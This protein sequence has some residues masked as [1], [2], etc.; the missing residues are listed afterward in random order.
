[1][2]ELPPGLR[3]PQRGGSLILPQCGTGQRLESVLGRKS[4]IRVRCFH[5]CQ[6]KRWSIVGRERLGR[7]NGVKL[8]EKKPPVAMATGG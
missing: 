7:P 6:V 4:G 8:G 1:M 2:H 5:A 3:S